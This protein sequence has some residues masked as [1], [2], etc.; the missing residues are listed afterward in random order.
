M[1]KEELSNER[2][3][4]REQRRDGENSTYEKGSQATFKDL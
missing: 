4:R 1:E 2:K 3:Q